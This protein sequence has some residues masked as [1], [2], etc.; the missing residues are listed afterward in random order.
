MFKNIEKAQFCRG[1]SLWRCSD[2]PWTGGSVG[3]SIVPYTKRLWV[4]SPVRSCAWG[5]RLMFVS[6]IDV[7]LSHQCPPTALLSLSE[8]NKQILWWGF[9]KTNSHKTKFNMF[10]AWKQISISGMHKMKQVTHLGCCRLWD[11][12]WVYLEVKWEYCWSCEQA[13]DSI[14]LWLWKVSMAVVWG[15]RGLAEGQWLSGVDMAAHA[16]SWCLNQQSSY[17]CGREEMRTTWETKS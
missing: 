16:R 8:I 10:K 15:S 17:K 2:K 4:Q 9:E 1:I 12:V 13:G 6:Q 5:N 7:S 3:W 11:G 14:C